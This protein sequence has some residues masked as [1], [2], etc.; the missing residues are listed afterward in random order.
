[1]IPDNFLDELRARTSLSRLVGA[2]VRLTKAGGEQKGCCPFHQEKTPSFYVNDDK[3]F[4]HCFGCSAHGD[5]LT[6]LVE[7]DGLE[8]LE[9]VQRLADDAGL[10][11]PRRQE[12]VDERTDGLRGVVERAGD[13]FR[14]QLDG[15]DGAEA[16]AYLQ[17]R[18]VDADLARRFGLGLAPEGGRLR[19]AL[20][21]EGEAVLLEAGLL[22]RREEG[23]E[24][25]ER[26]R[27]RIVFPVDDARGRPAGFSGRIL[28]RG[29]PKY[30]NTPETPLFDKGR[31]LFNLHRAAP[32]ARRAGR[33]I[34]VEGQM[35]VVGLARVGIDEV[36][37]PLGTAVTE[38]QV[39]LMWRVAREPIVLLDGDAA[40]RRA[41]GRI[42]RLA[43]PGV[44]PERSLRFAMLPEGQD[45]DDLA[46]HGGAE[47]VERV[48]AAAV[49]L[50]DLLWAR[51]RDAAVTTTPEGRAKLREALVAL[52]R[53]I[54]HRD[55][56][57]EYE[58]DFRGRV[59]RLFERPRYA[60]R[61][62]PPTAQAAPVGSTE[63]R[64]VSA[65]I[66]GLARR[67][68]LAAREYERLA[69]LRLSSDAQRE[70]VD[71]IVGA[72]IDGRAPDAAAV[73]ALFPEEQ[74]WRGLALSFVRP[75]AYEPAAEADLCQTLD[76]LVAQQSGEEMEELLR[77][78]RGYERPEPP[79]VDPRERPGTR[80]SRLL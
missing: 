64:V 43:L 51:E 68:A 13:W 23:G 50:V 26:F 66:R 74:G 59:D 38:A 46:R 14:A 73:E 36:V 15:I 54:A 52:A 1:L 60:R 65:V 29:E 8:F 76:L 78:S 39:G 5:A 62:A 27:G 69:I 41:S 57:R 16:R 42:A 45:P 6:W 2:T 71:L 19:R 32:A 40:G 7:H 21:A 56:A 34:A 22:G 63:H 77:M 24:V 20:A 25:Y 9:A 44:E 17:R 75:G 47:A 72:A 31:L 70:A 18:G 30:L 4:Y 58:N 80:L 37:A 28:G 10:E 61:A 53:T 33:L 11:V 35:D 55:L 79:V 12:R 3:A 67:P 48:L 49:P